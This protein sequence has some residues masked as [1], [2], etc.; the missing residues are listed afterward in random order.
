M[1]RFEIA[2]APEDGAGGGETAPVAAPAEAAA[3]P[4]EAPAAEAAPGAPAATEAPSGLLVDAPAKIEEAPKPDAAVEAPKAETEAVAEPP[5][6]EDAPK[7]EEA[8]AP[9][10]EPLKYEPFK[11]AEGVKPIDSIMSEF[12]KIVGAKHL[13]QEQAQALV[14]LS[15]KYAEEIGR[16]AQQAQIEHWRS[17][18]GQWKED[19][20]KD[21]DLGG[22]NEMRT[23]AT[24]KAVIE[25]FGG[26]REQVQDML[27]HISENQGNG[28]SNYSGFIRLLKNIG[29]R[30][31]VFEDKMIV[32]QSGSSSPA[33]DP[34]TARQQRRYPTMSANRT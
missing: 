31:N 13:P 18:N 5:K 11:F 3:T 19:F 9:E 33:Q 22:Q 10:P 30:M 21:P 14:D 16:Q 20:R 23:L 12:E 8:P 24:A 34:E 4:V 6:T 2:R 26:T 17:L 27:R 7:A 28:M 32:T 1:L 15:A 29:E 25:E